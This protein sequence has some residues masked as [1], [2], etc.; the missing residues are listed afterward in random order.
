VYP[1]FDDKGS[2]FIAVLDG[3]AGFAVAQEGVKLFPQELKVRGHI[4]PAVA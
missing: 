1:F 2:A 4:G 3:H